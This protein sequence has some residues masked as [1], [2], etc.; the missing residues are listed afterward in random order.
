MGQ[1]RGSKFKVQRSQKVIFYLWVKVKGRGQGQS[2]FRGQGQNSRS[3]MWCVAIETRG[4]ACRVQQMTITSGL[5]Q[6]VVI[7]SPMNFTVCL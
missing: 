3:N 6:K 7:T 1:G 5:A 2:R 4:L